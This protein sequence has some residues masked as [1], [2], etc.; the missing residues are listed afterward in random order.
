MIGHGGDPVGPGLQDL[1]RAGLRVVA[2]AL[3]DDGAD[4][5][6]RNRVAHEHDVR[7]LAEREPRDAV[8]AERQRFDA[9]LEL[10]PAV[11]F[12]GRGLGRH[13]ARMTASP[14]APRGAAALTTG[15]QLVDLGQQLVEL[16][17]PR[18][19]DPL[20]EVL[21]VAGHDAAVAHRVVERVLETLDGQHDVLGE[22]VAQRPEA[23]DQRDVAPRLGAV[24]RA[25][26]VRLLRR[27]G[28]VLTRGLRDRRLGA[29]FFAGV[30]ASSRGAGFLARRGLAL[31]AGLA[32][33]GGLRLRSRRSPP[34][35]GRGLRAVRAPPSS[36]ARLRG[37]AA[38][39]A[40]SRGRR[41]LAFAGQPSSRCPRRSW[42]ALGHPPI[43]QSSSSHSSSAFW[44][45]RRFSAWVQIICRAP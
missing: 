7:A 18:V 23:V 2:L 3:R 20:A 14:G 17:A 21:G 22:Q 37:G 1:E 24:A 11:G 44:A 27:T 39:A 10:L 42:L 29:G 4:A 32:L 35:A 28:P 43:S 8:A 19:G 26:T 25:P 38:F 40:P 36:R 33:R 31:A 34:S 13:G 30:G 41:A 12:A 15:A 45:W 6:A 5:V 9:E 16:A